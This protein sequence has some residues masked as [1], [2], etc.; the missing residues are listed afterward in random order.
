MLLAAVV[1]VVVVVAE[2][3]EEEEEETC[4]LTSRPGNG[5]CSGFPVRR[6]SSRR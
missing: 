4:S 3:E 1:E 6:C 5:A 2:E